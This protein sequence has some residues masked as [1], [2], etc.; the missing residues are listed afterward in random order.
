LLRRFGIASPDDEAAEPEAAQHADAGGAGDGD[1]TASRP[2]PRDEHEEDS[3]DDYMARLLERL[4]AKGVS[5]RTSELEPSRRPT[6]APTREPERQE[7]A[8]EPPKLLR[9]PSEMAPRAVAA[10]SSR[11]LSAMRELAILNARAAIDLHERQ[12]LIQ[13]FFSKAFT[14]F[15]A[16]VAAALLFWFY[17]QGNEASLPL[18]LLALAAAVVWAWQ[19]LA[20]RQAARRRR[21]W[22]EN[23]PT[24]AKEPHDAPPTPADLSTDEELASSP[25]P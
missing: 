4:G 19:Y 14:S 20:L 25:A 21:R 15:V 17:L 1:E 11:D 16:I 5:Q 22:P 13:R 8:P 18:A 12:T 9:D 24:D 6:K 10:E 23:A 7:A 2:A 3:I